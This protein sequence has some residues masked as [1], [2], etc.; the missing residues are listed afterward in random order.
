[1]L[2]TDELHFKVIDISYKLYECVN[3][4]LESASGGLLFFQLLCR[5]LII[6]KVLLVDLQQLLVSQSSIGDRM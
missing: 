5:F 6:I 1:M 2:E 3:L 4:Y